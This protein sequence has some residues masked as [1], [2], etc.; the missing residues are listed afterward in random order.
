MNYGEIIVGLVAAVALILT[1]WQMYAKKDVA[2]T[3][4]VKEI[5]QT[6]EAMLEDFSRV[7]EVA[8]DAVQAAEQLWAT[9]QIPEVSP[10][11]KHPKFYYAL[12]ILKTAYPKVT[13]A[14]LENA[15][16]SA[17]FVMNK[18]YGGL[19]RKES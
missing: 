17:V 14:I 11:V 2:E 5:V 9:G 8:K 15:I 12:G 16:E 7:S 4:T 10:G 18:L 6:T 3:I 1:L 13:E 19:K